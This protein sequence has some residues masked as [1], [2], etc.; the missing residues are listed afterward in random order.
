MPNR[1]KKQLQQIGVAEMRFLRPV[2]GY[3]RMDQR[4]NDDIQKLNIF[5]LS[6]KKLININQITMNTS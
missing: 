4:R 6:K 5:D 2:A 3:R 1:N